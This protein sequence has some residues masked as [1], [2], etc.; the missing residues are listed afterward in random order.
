[1]CGIF[2]C[3]GHIAE[4]HAAACLDTLQHRGPDGAGLWHT[5]A[6][7]LGH[8]RLSILDLSATGS[9]PM[10]Y[11]DG[12]F[13]ITFN[14]EIYNFLEI[15]QKL[16]QY[17]HRFTSESDTEV[18][19][20][21]YAQ[22]GADCVERF[23]GMWAFA[24]WDDRDKSLFLSR[25]R[26]GKKPLF[27]AEIQGNFVFASEMKAIYPLLP[28]VRPSAD[29][30]WMK[31]NLFAYE[32]TEKC[33]VAGIRRFPAGHSGVLKSGRLAL[34][35]YWNTLEHL[36]AVP[37]RYEEQVEEFRAL[38]LDACRIRMRSDVPIG[39][40]LSGGIDSSAVASAMAHIARHTGGARVAADW[41]HAF[42]ATFP[43]SP[44]DETA[45]ARAVVEKHDLNATL[46]EIDPQKSLA[47]LERYFY[48]F[49]ELYVTSP[50]PMVQLYAGMRNARVFVTLD[51]HGADE[52]FVGYPNE[53]FE[54]AIDCDI[55]VDEIAEL[56][57]EMFPRDSPQFRV[58]GNNRVLYSYFVL[59][60]LTKALLRRRQPSR[61]AAHPGFAR[62][63]RFNQYLYALT[64]DT[65]LPTLLRNY[66]RY[67]MIN[68]V[69]VRAPFMD[70]R[71]V[72]YAFSIPMRSK[73]G[74]GYTKKIV[75][76]AVGDLMP[77]EIV[78]RRT[79][80]GFNSP[81]VDWMRRQM[82][83]YFLDLVNS[84]SFRTSAF[85]DAK[86]VKRRVEAV[87]DGSQSRFGYAER[88]WKQL[89]PYLWEQ[90]VL[91]RRYRLA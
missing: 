5:E 12:R 35:R 27:Y 48:Q 67:S 69:E 85:I 4:R 86:R 33:L 11:G 61:D 78:T 60:K 58:A 45:Y 46:I 39:T 72:S 89:V 79:K 66:D 63:D 43:G 64:H 42:V 83:E 13:R 17:G 22:W 68:G 41:Q 21:A 90:A 77:A 56:Y 29:F 59:R 18:I 37:S 34:R 73:I 49:E 40:A 36:V 65:I 50:I 87:I 51:G 55:E 6:V 84:E 24:I 70:H 7:T 57:R 31:R 26:F 14:G 1:M 32:T 20:A 54:A 9:Q 88:T 3:V 47:D 23:N 25:D 53:L 16:E 76:D 81:I 10:A 19:L 2:G 30:D 82:R 71:I 52:L 75:R 74:G 15:R 28:D 38:F 62:L 80:V 91:K 8:R 44:L